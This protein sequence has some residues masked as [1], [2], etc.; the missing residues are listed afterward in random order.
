MLNKINKWLITGGAALSIAGSA[1]IYDYFKNP[2]GIELLNDS[3]YIGRVEKFFDKQPRAVLKSISEEVNYVLDRMDYIP[4]LEKIGG[5]LQNLSDTN[6]P[7]N[8]LVKYEVLD[9]TKDLKKTADRYDGNVGLLCLGAV[10]GGVG[11][12]FFGT[13]ISNYLNTRRKEKF[14]V[15][16]IDTAIYTQ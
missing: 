10:F 9:L 13:G 16:S 15:P 3:S 7:S 8:P 12:S 6:D 11:A 1:L 5:R 14:A 4:N 2:D